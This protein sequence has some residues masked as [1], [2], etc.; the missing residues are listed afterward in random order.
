MQN[1]WHLFVGFGAASACVHRLLDEIF[2]FNRILVNSIS[3]S[4]IRVKQVSS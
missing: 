2:H 3:I 4:I 1:S